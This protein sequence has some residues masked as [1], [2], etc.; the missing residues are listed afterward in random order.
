M[1]KTGSFF[2]DENSVHFNKNKSVL[3]VPLKSVDELNYVF[4]IEDMIK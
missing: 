1:I 3:D 2:S 4:E